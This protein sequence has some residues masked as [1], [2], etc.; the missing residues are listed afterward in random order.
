M[1]KRGW[2]ALAAVVTAGVVAVVAV[3]SARSAARADTSPASTPTE[4][5]ITVTSTASVGTA[6]DEAVIDLGVT[7][8]G[9]DAASALDANAA[10]AKAVVD[11]LL[12]TGLTKSD[13]E[14]TRVSL[15]HHIVDRGT[16]SEHVEYTGSTGIEVT[17]TD[18][19][20]VGATIAAA[21]HAG[22]NQLHGVRFDVSDQAAARERALAQAV[23]T[24]R[25]KAD[26]MA[27]A[28]GTSVS[29]VIQIREQAAVTQP[30]YAQARLSSFAAADAMPAPQV[31]A[32]QKLP[33][34]VTVQVVWSLG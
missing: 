12:R 23:T 31:I 14:T 2:V 32:P 24:A 17:V 15:A 19:S 3:T 33:T 25:A 6:P 20:S 22:A 26:T 8:P 21:V 1:E 34:K 13:L 16:A 9:V 18:L 30:Y 27:K 5:S 10:S 28:A 4:H 29:G 11:A 7:S